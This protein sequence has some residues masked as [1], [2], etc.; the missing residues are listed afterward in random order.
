MAENGRASWGRGHAL[1]GQPCTRCSASGRHAM[2]DKAGV[3]QLDIAA[4]TA[5]T[6]LST[7]GTVSRPGT[8]TVPTT[9]VEQGSPRCTA[10]GY[11]RPKPGAGATGL[12]G[13]TTGGVSADSASDVRVGQLSGAGAEAAA[14]WHAKAQSSRGSGSKRNESHSWKK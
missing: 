6:A 11:N 8:D 10:N 9:G 2:A 14:V 1:V 13:H 4:R 7:L 5:S 3:L 12:V